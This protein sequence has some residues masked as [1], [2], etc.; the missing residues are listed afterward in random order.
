MNTKIRKGI[1]SNEAIEKS[2]FILKTEHI[3]GY[4]FRQQMKPNF[5]PE[6]LITKTFTNVKNLYK[7]PNS[8]KSRQT[9]ASVQMD[10]TYC[11]SQRLRPTAL[12][13]RW[14]TT[15]YQNNAYPNKGAG[16]GH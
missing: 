7:A 11:E 4:W 13:T 12:S 10:K 8:A 3:A 15:Y 5:W 9:V 16:F 14:H 2:S 6:K 1:Q